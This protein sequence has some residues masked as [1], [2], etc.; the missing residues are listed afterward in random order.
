[1]VRPLTADDAVTLVPLNDAAAPAVP[2]TSA[3]D[4]AR[5]I[6]LSS[7]ALAAQRDDT[8][9]GFIIAISPGADYDSE[10]YRFFESRTTD[11]LYVDRIV[12]DEQERGSGLGS[13][14]YDAV[15][16]AARRDGRAEVTCEVNLDPPNPRSMAFHERLG[17]VRVATQETKAGTVT[18]ALLAA[19]VASD[20]SALRP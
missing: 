8:I 18:V 10:N 6:E 17:F 20:R 12:I 19:S 3:A 1:M 4:L 2:L 7:L 5:L 16:D 13:A 15:F 14:L 9:V 11:H